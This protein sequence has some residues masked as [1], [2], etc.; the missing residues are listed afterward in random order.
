M[1]GEGEAMKATIT[2]PDGTV[3]TL[4]SVNVDDVVRAVRDLAGPQ[5]VFV[6]SPWHIDPRPAAPTIAWTTRTA[7]TST[8][9][10]V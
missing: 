3:V 7:T 9:E 6:P 4:E 2:K 5:V 1:G 10:P 8:P